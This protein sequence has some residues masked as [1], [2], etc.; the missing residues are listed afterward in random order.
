MTKIRQMTI[1]KWKPKLEKEK[2]G[3]FVVSKLR[4]A[5]FKNS[6]FVGGYVRDLLLGRQETGAIDV[7]T[8]ATPKQVIKVL[9]R[10]RIRT[11]PTGLK[12]GTVTAHQKGVDIEITTFR[13]EGKYLDA[14]RPSAVKFIRSVEQD[15]AR[16]DFTVNALYFDPITKKVLDFA[17]GLDDLEK[18]TLR[19]VGSPKKRIAEDALRLMRAVRF[20]TT[21]GFKFSSGVERA[22]RAGAPL[23]K[24][25]SRERVKQELDRIMISP[26]RA[27]GVGIL[28]RIGLLGLILPEFDRLSKVRQSKNYHSEGNVFVHTLLA[29][30]L[31]EHNT[32]LSTIYGL[33]F[34]DIGKQNTSQETKKRGRAHISFHGHQDSGEGIVRKIL[35]R[36]RFSNREVEDITWYVRNHHVPVDLPNMREA[37]RVAWCLDP[38]FE[39]LL[40][41]FRADSL[42]SIPSDSRGRK[43]KPSL[44]LYDYARNAWLEVKKRKIVER[45]VSGHEI[46]KILAIPEG[47]QVGRVLSKIRELQLEGK[48]VSK[49]QVLDYLKKNRKVL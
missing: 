44:K 46:M 8:E 43:L 30:E 37:K 5:G 34:H 10:S 32:D 49:K 47:V 39:N 31:I 19:F 41:L 20:A 27:D 7:A 28:K 23:I 25:I 4:S 22:L 38:R 1:L 3:V 18:K 15:S 13:S 2:V 14:R 9:A 6:F 12:H 24:K 45:L 26:K 29:L 16:R 48:I 36:L 35:P 33:L 42:A 17:G 40:K 11:I 21:L